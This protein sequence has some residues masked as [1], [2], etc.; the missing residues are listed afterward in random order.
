[1]SDNIPPFHIQTEILQRLPVKSLVKFRSVS[2][3]WKSVI[4]SSNFIKNHSQYQPHLLMIHSKHI[5]LFFGIPWLENLFPFKSPMDCG[6]NDHIG[7]GFCPDPMLVRINVSRSRWEVDVFTLS[8]R[9]WKRAYDFSNEEFDDDV[10]VIVSFDLK[11]YKFGKLPLPDRLSLIRK[12]RVAEVKDSLGVLEYDGDGGYGVWIMEFV[13]KSFTKMFTVKVSGKLLNNGVLK[14]KNP[15]WDISMVLGLME[16]MECLLRHQEWQR[17]EQ[18][19]IKANLQHMSLLLALLLLFQALFLAMI[20]E[21]QHNGWSLVVLGKGL[22]QIWSFLVPV[23]TDYL[24]VS[25]HKL[26]LDTELFIFHVRI[27]ES[28]VTHALSPADFIKEMQGCGG[29]FTGR[30]LLRNSLIDM[31][32]KYGFLGYA[33]GVFV[34]M[35]EVDVISWSS[36]IAG[37]SK[38]GYEDTAFEQ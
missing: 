14:L 15:P 27:K 38:L 29:W 30:L 7:F 8:S 2:K 13:T 19:N 6:Q 24:N 33:N 18:N 11:S 9:V 10:N 21:F 32:N 31:Y 23:K 3:L 34:N 1:M 20:L 4:D 35:E 37:C 16:T 5:S 26:K 22:G 12:W 25:A 17:I 36:W 28:T